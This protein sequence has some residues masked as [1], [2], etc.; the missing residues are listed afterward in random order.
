MAWADVQ[1]RDE[2][3][4]YLRYGAAVFALVVL[5]IVALQLSRS[6][7]RIGSAVEV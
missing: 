3:R 6:G 4:M 2:K 5:S 7:V 1:H